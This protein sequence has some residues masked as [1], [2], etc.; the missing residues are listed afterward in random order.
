MSV[1]LIGPTAGDVAADLVDCSP[2]L[3]DVLDVSVSKGD[4]E[5]HLAASAGERLPGAV[6]ICDEGK[7]ALHA[8]VTT[9]GLWRCRPES[10][11][12]R[13]DGT[14]SLHQAFRFPDASGAPLL[15]PLGGRLKFIAVSEVACDPMVIDEDFIEVVAQAVH[16][17]YV[18]Q[19][20]R[21]GESSAE[22]AVLVDWYELPDGFR[23]ANRDQARDIGRKLGLIN[24]V[25]M[26]NTP[27]R[28]SEF[29]FTAE[30]LEMLAEREH[31]RWSAERERSGWRYSARRD[32]SI[33]V[34]SDLVPYQDLDEP[35]KD[36][37]RQAVAAVIEILGELGLQIV[38]TT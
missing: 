8:A 11:V 24:C 15:D 1:V 2:H 7:S 26:P 37:D 3:A 22:S 32:D 23:K 5:S 20:T 36:K 10:V 19:R 30:E 34:Y 16:E 4:L 29:R 9:A 27:G 12:V 18:A 35:T 28:P 25:L 33:K 14:R 13:V 21:D 38:R 17:H 31:E 6:F